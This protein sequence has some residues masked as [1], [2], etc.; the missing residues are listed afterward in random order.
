MLITGRRRNAVVADQWL[1]KNKN[2]AAVRRVSHR[3]RV[4]N[5]RGSEDGFARDVGF[6]AKRLSGEDGSILKKAVSDVF[7]AFSQQCAHTL[8]VNVA[9]SVEMGVDLRCGPG[10]CLVVLLCTVAMKRAC[11]RVFVTCP[12]APADRTVE[13]LKS[14]EI[15][16]RRDSDQRSYIVALGW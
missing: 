9:L 14:C 8:M 2:L 15:M 4:S 10:T 1:C 3:L 13:G 7:N 6:G 12:R 16:L 11:A 5:K